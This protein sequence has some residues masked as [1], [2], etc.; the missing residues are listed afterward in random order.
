MISIYESFH[1]FE[2]QTTKQIWISDK[3]HD[4]GEMEIAN[5]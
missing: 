5:T 1:G 2:T 3:L 4:I